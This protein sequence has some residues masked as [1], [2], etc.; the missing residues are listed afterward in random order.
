[1]GLLQTAR[2]GFGPEYWLLSAS[3]PWRQIILD[4]FLRATDM[5]QA[6]QL[7]GALA[8]F[9]AEWVSSRDILSRSLTAASRCA[10]QISGRTFLEF[11]VGFARRALSA[12]R[13]TR[14]KIECAF[15]RL[16]GFGP[17]ISFQGNLRRRA[18]RAKNG[19]VA[20]ALERASAIGRYRRARLDD[21]W[22]GGLTRTRGATPGAIRHRS[23]NY[24]AACCIWSTICRSRSGF[25]S[26][27]RETGLSL[28]R[29]KISP[30]RAGA[31]VP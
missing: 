12:A 9:C 5:G 6:Y 16:V 10:C 11:S 18:R 20:A 22:L 15:V 31:I 25:N 23:S 26:T 24:P 28:R 14:E 8:Q 19:A 4:D 7:A 3:R 1:M 13:A 21:Q 30:C 2:Q 17:F 29:R 27:S